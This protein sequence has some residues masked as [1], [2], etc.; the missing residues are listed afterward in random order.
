MV[1][2]LIRRDCCRATVVRFTRFPRHWRRSVHTGYPWRVQCASM[3]CAIWFQ[4]SRSR[5]RHRRRV[6]GTLLRY[7]RMRR[8]PKFQL[9]RC[10]LQLTCAMRTFARIW[11]PP[12]DSGRMWSR[13][14][15]CAATGVWQR[16]QRP[17]SRAYISL[18]ENRSTTHAPDRRAAAQCAYSRAFRFFELRRLM[19]IQPTTRPPARREFP[20]LH[21]A[22]D[23]VSVVLQEVVC[24][25]LPPPHT[26][27]HGEDPAIPTRGGLEIE[28]LHPHRELGRG[29]VPSGVF[30]FLCSSGRGL[31]KPS[32]RNGG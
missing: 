6:H 3:S 25:R 27:Q 23:D 1:A 32:R 4:N 21:V 22:R 5:D 20:Y 29:C 30:A 17:L 12:Q 18:R 2:A 8:S 16:P 19:R 31:T 14:A 10:A 11:S 15:S 7:R 13:V 9:P 28:R 26:P 24:E